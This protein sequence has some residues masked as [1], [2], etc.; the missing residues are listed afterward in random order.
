MTG[1][2][3]LPARR[4]C[5]HRLDGTGI[6]C[7][8]Q[9]IRGWITIHGKMG[10]LSVVVTVCGEDGKVA[11]PQTLLAAA[12]PGK[13]HDLL[14]EVHFRAPIAAD[15]RFVKP[16]ELAAGSDRPQPVAGT[17]GHPSRAV[18]QREIVL[19]GHRPTKFKARKDPNR[20]ETTMPFASTSQHSRDA[21][22]TLHQKGRCDPP[23]VQWRGCRSARSRFP[24]RCG[25]TC[26]SALNV[27][28]GVH[29]TAW[30]RHFQTAAFLSQRRIVFGRA[31][32]S[33]RTR[34]SGRTGARVRAAGVSR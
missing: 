30:Q 32:M 4:R 10:R 8:S 34:P 20:A 29:H 11:S 22:C 5:Q 23:P 3:S 25:C 16:S 17:K 26:G 7:T 24:P 14:I 12:A 31:G 1:R 28:G 18:A 27:D 6:Y 21:N 13:A 9:Y 15:H 2:A 33:L 19:G